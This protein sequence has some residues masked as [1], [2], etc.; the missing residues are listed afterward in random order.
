MFGLGMPELLVIL[1]I[2]LLLFGAEKIPELARGLARIYRE[3]QKATRDIQDTILSADLES[4][5]KSPYL[6]HKDVRRSE[7][8]EA[9]GALGGPDF[10]E[11][12]GRD[13][14]GDA[15]DVEGD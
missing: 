9:M 3:I 2:A 10:P 7:D 8:S 13:S 4:P 1:F 12:S 15:K 6:S 14:L 11:E 5:P